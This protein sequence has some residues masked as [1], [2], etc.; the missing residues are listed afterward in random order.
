MFQ[1]HRG[2]GELSPLSASL[3]ALIFL[4]ALLMIATALA[5]GAQLRKLD[6]MPFGRPPTGSR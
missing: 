3:A 4:V 2:T 1:T 6:G 5:L